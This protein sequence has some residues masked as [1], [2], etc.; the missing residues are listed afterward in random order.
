MPSGIQSIGNQFSINALLLNTLNKTNA[1]FAT[2]AKEIA[3]G[4]K[5]DLNPQTLAQGLKILSELASFQGQTGSLQV[6]QS[7]AAVQQG[8]LALANDA[9]NDLQQLVIQKNSGFADDATIA[10]IDSA[11]S[12]TVNSIGSLLGTGSSPFGGGGTIQATDDTA[13]IL[14]DVTVTQT[15]GSSSGKTLDITV[16]SVGTAATTTLTAPG[17][18][19]TFELNGVTINAASGSSAD[20]T[21]AVNAVSDE[22]G[23]TA[24]DNTGTLTL[25]QSTA[26]SANS[27]SV[28][29]VTGGQFGAG[30]AGIFSG[31]D[32]SLTINGTSVTGN[33]NDISIS[34]VGDVTATFTVDAATAAGTTTSITTE[35][36]GTQYFTGDGNSI[37]V[38][39]PGTFGLAQLSNGGT[40]DFAADLALINDFQNSVINSQVQV[41][42][43]QGAQASASNSID[44]QIS[45][46][47]QAS[48]DILGADFGASISGL[49][50]SVNQQKLQ[51]SLIAQNNKFG[52][53]LLTLL[54]N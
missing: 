7:A 29:N 28:Q 16:N 21:A 25:T 30:E 54:N 22:T 50:S 9:A 11:I 51:I 38:A 5:Q 43:V 20:I 34:N 47:S 41:A 23:V 52:S 17:T 13:G 36:G 8:N 27:I 10:A 42:T 26:G 46:L 6:S 45:S 14:S 39:S 53:G 24:V 33:G 19:T 37:T 4:K 15:T 49:L 1:T 44:S 12:N 2:K 18:A 31:T 32:A 48:A 3:T 35:G 40:G